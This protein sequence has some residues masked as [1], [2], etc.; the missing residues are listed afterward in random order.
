MAPQ[1]TPGD[2]SL[3]EESK[4]VVRRRGERVERI[5]RPRMPDLTGEP[6]T[7]HRAVAEAEVAVSQETLSAIVDGTNPKGDV[8]SVAETAGVM[9]GKRASDLVPLV[10]TAGLTE[11]FVTAVPDR[12][13]GAVRIRSEVAALGVSGVEV[14]ALTAAA[15]AG[16]TVYDMIRDLEPEAEI[17]AVRLI[18][19]E[20]GEQEAWRRQRDPAGGQK[21]PRGARIAGRV[22]SG[23]FRGPGSR[24]R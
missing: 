1:V 2:G 10:H 15:V 12:A 6:L 11:L 7:V 14:E 20:S 9:A 3:F 22:G 13:A 5:A 8:L 19:A 4:R 23:P 17:R 21:A 16:L 18:S 24:P